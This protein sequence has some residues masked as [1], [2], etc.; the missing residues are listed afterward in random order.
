[1]A[2]YKALIYTWAREMKS[3]VIMTDSKTALRKIATPVYGERILETL[4]DFTE[5]LKHMIRT[6]YSVEL[7]EVPGHSGVSGNETTDRGAK[8]GIMLSRVIEARRILTLFL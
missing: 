7:V 8:K 6:G 3:P 5:K 1:M 2:I 4:L